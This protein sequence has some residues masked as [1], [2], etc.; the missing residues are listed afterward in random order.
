M[1]NTMHFAGSHD[2]ALDYFN[3]CRAAAVPGPLARL[4]RS[5]VLWNAARQTRDELMKL[6]DRE[7]DD[8]GLTRSQIDDVA[9]SI[10]RG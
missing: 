4:Y 8:V 3:D 10:W 2:P 5:L 1:A 6:N 9:N 7:L